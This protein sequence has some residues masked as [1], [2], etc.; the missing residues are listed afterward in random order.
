MCSVNRSGSLNPTARPESNCHFEEW[1]EHK[2]TKDVLQSLAKIEERILTGSLAFDFQN[3]LSK[4]ETQLLEVGNI[5]ACLLL[6]K[7]SLV[8]MI[9]LGMTDANDGKIARMLKDIPAT[10]TQDFAPLLV[11]LMTEIR[12]GNLG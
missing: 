1:A 12:G 11:K 9:E 8:H 3:D 6:S 2:L 5:K 4:A 7:L 10:R